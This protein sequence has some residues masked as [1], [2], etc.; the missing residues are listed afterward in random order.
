MRV[1]VDTNCLLASVPPKGK[2]GNADY[3]ITNDRHFDILKGME[4][5]VVN[6]IPLDDFKKLIH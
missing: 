4:F 5:P 6:V 3:L 1:V 2:A